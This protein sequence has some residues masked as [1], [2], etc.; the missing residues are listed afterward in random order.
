MVLEF[1][2]GAKSA[3]SGMSSLQEVTL[4]RVSK[5]NMKYVMVLLRPIYH[6]VKE[7]RQDGKK[8]WW[9][10]LVRLTDKKE[11]GLYVEVRGSTESEIRQKIKAYH[12]PKFLQLS[13]VEVKNHST[14]LAGF[15]ADITKYG[16]VQPV[17]ESHP[18]IACLR[19]KFPVAKSDFSILLEHCQGY[20][21]VDLIGLVTLK[22]TPPTKVPKVTL[23]LKD[24]SQTELAVNLWGQQMF[25]L[26]TKIMEGMVVQIENALL[27]KKQDGSVEASAEHWSDSKKNFFSTIHLEPEGDRVKKLGALSSERGNAV[28]IPWSLQT[29]AVR[30]QTDGLDKYIT[31]CSNVSVCSLAIEEGNQDIVEVQLNG[32]WVVG[33]LGEPFYL[34]C[35]QCRTKINPET[36]LCK[37][38]ATHG[39]QTERDAEEAILA[40]V[41]VADHSGQLERVLVPENMLCALTGFESKEILIQDVK[42]YGSQIL[43]FRQPVDIRLATNSYLKQLS[44]PSTS[45]QP[46]GFTTQQV[47]ESQDQESAQILLP[48]CQF[49]VVAAKN[50]LFASYSNDQRPMIRKVLRLEK[51]RVADVIYPIKCLYTE[52]QFSS[53]GV[54]LKK[55]PIFPLYITCVAVA[56]D[57]EPILRQVGDASDQHYMMIH[58]KVFAYAGEKTMFS[59]EALCPLTRTHL[60]NMAD[61]HPRLLIG[62]PTFDGNKI[63]LIAERMFKLVDEE[64]HA[65]ILEAERAAIEELQSLEASLSKKRRASDLLLET[66]AKVKG[67]WIEQE[68]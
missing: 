65:K 58:E 45:S 23:W 22:E 32:V 35:K 21:R 48:E 41:N 66:P 63:T 60:W 20:E 1:L 34:P 52:L 37:R 7:M 31:C 50:A 42:K 61:R 2:R 29:G 68:V 36:G 12:E 17:A 33:I 27:A 11:Q 39:C 67:R 40:T 44:Q 9:K 55:Y 30:L 62:K 43:C 47:L 53:F 13:E 18:N 51:R 26:A 56:E 15:S 25:T 38:H 6:E 3:S 5:S 54:K 64:N 10:G 8:S 28:S 46:S 24:E 57:D 4:E 19:N 59:V 14:F 49:Q 16:K